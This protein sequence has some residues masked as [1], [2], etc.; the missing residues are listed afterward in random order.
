M[1]TPLPSSAAS[2]PSLPTPPP[3]PAAPSEAARPGLVLLCLLALYIVWGSTYLGIR[4]ALEGGWPPFLMAGSR[5]VLAGALLY[6][7]L[8]LKGW[9]RPRGREWASAAVVGTL[10]LGVGNGGVVFAQQ[11][12]PSALA[13]VVVGTMPLWAALFGGLFGA[14]W[15]GWAERAGLLLGFAGVVLLEAG[16]GVGGPRLAALVLLV[17]P[18]S[19][20]FGSVWGR[21]LPQAPGLM[22]TAAQM[23]CGGA[24]MLVLA[25]VRREWP[26][27]PPT[28]AGWGAFLYLVMFGSLVAFSAYGY[29]L[30]HA[31]PAVATSYAYVNPAVAVLLGVGLV[32][33]RLAPEAFA[34]M[35]CILAAVALITRRQAARRTPA[36]ARR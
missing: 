3:P 7:V 33:E 13:A 18:L 11:W 32:G 17:A 26:A 10:L 24:G 12:V 22:N 25:A 28:L 4:V 29:L 6:G 34:A 5:F 19:W 30:R 8:R 21:R 2:E 36:A 14:G 31:R 16:G 27:H 23:L 15:P 20:A 1:A 9:A 35:G